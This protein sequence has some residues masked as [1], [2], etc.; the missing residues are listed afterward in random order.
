MAASCL[1][2]TTCIIRS[3]VSHVR[4]HFHM[5]VL[6]H[7]DHFTV[8]QNTTVLFFFEVEHA[9]VCR[10]SGRGRSSIYSVSWS[11]ANFSAPLS[12]LSLSLQWTLNGGGTTPR[13][14]GGSTRPCMHGHHSSNSGGGESVRRPG[15]RH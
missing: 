1:L 12:S 9:A 4:F 14:G 7:G 6:T 5:S 10:R 13:E 2:L 8:V 15:L 11:G 3:V